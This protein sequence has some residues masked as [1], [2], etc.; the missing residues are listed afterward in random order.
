M[1]VTYGD[2]NS[3]GMM[4]SNDW[5]NQGTLEAGANIAIA[6]L[7]DVGTSM[8]N[9]V[10]PEAM[11]ISTRGIL[12]DIGA[13]GAVS[14]YDNNRAAVEALSF[15]G[16]I[17]IPGMAATKIAS[18]VRAGMRGTSFLSDLRHKDDLVKFANLIEGGATGTAEYRSLRNG[19]YGR[20]A[21][22]NLTDAAAAEFAI[23]S[24][25]NAHPFMEDYMKN[26]VENFAI[27]M[28]I[29]GGV[30]TGI[31]N[32]IQR[33]ELRGITG[34]V[35][36]TATG[37]VREAAQLHASSFSDTAST[38]TALN[39]AA[40]NLDTLAEQ[41]TT[42]PL[43]KEI[44]RSW[45]AGI[46]ANMGDI[47]RASASE[48][49][50]ATGTDELAKI[51]S[52][53][54]RPEFMGAEKFDFFKSAAKGYAE[55]ATPFALNPLAVF[56]RTN[57][58]GKEV[59]IPA[60]FYSQDSQ[61]FLTRENANLLANAADTTSVAGVDKLA[62]SL[63]LRRVR[64]L[65]GEVDSFGRSGDVEAHYLANMK[66]YG[67]QTSEN[68]AAA[69]IV[70]GDMP[71]MH[72]WISAVTQKTQDA[73]QIINNP[74]STA[75][76][77]A[78]AMK[79]L[80]DLSN[81]RLKIFNEDQVKLVR[82][83]EV[84][85][86]P[87][88]ATTLDP[89]SLVSPTYFDDLMGSISSGNIRPLIRDGFGFTN[90]QDIAS[91]FY[92]MVQQKENL[93]TLADM[94]QVSARKLED[95]SRQYALDNSTKILGAMDEGAGL[96]AAATL[97]LIRWIGGRQEDKE[98]FR[99]AM[100]SARTMRNG[101][102]STTPF[103]DELA[104]ILRSPRVK[105]QMEE[106]TKH[107]DAKGNIYLKRGMSQDAVGDTP[108][109][110]YT[111]NGNIASGFGKVS[112]YKIHKD[113]VVGYLYRGE[114]EWLVGASARDTVENAAK[115]PAP[116]PAKTAA[117]AYSSTNVND[118]S[119]AML[120]AKN[121]SIAKAIQDGMAPEVAAIRYNTSKEMAQLAAADPFAFTRLAQAK[122]VDVAMTTVN[123]WNSPLQI[124]DA[125]SATRKTLRVSAAREKLT[126]SNGQLLKLHHDSLNGLLNL[127][128]QQKMALEAMDSVASERI[129]SK[130]AVLDEQFATIQK[131]WVE[132]SVVGS[133]SPLLRSMLGDVVDSAE[134]KTLREG[135][136]QFVNGKGGNPLYSSADFVTSRM[137]V[138]GR[139][140]TA[141]GDRR[142]ELANRE[143]ERLATP[144]AA[145]FKK[146]QKDEVARTEFAMMDNIRQST[147][148]IAKY[149]PVERTWVAPDGNWVPV[150]GETQPMAPIT[151]LRVQSD[152]VHEALIALDEASTAIHAT[153]SGLNRIKGSSPPNSI[154]T[155]IPSQYLGNKELAYVVNHDTGSIKLLAGNNPDDLKELVKSYSPQANET[156]MTREQLSMDRAAKLYDRLDDVTRADT[157]KLKKG[158]G[159]VA[160]DT[161]SD[162]LAD[163]VNGLRDRVNYQATAFVENSMTDLFQKLDYM[164]AVNNTFQGNKNPNVFQRA[165]NKVGQK[166]TAAD[167]KDI[168]L[169]KNPVH[170]SEFMGTINKTTSATIQLGLNAF[171]NAYSVVKPAVD[172]LGN[173]KG[174]G[175]DYEKF[176]T[177][178]KAQ[179]IEDPFKAFNEAAR[180]ALY[181]RARNSGYSVT[182]DRIINA[183]NA[184]ASTMALKFMELAQP[185]VNMMSAPILATSVISRSIKAAQIENGG[186]LLRVSSMATMMNGVRRAHSAL[187]ENQKFLK[188]F[189]QDGLFSSIVSEAD[190]VIKMSRFGT[191]S[192][193]GGLE[194]ALDSKFVQVMSKPSEL[195]ESQLRR[196]TLMTGVELGRRIYGPAASDRQIAIYARDFLKQSLGNYSTSQRPMMFQGSF[197]AAMGLFQTYMLTY[198]QS[199]YR[200][201]D[202]K[203]YK[204]LGKTMLA[205]GGIFG[206]GSLPGFHPVSQAIGEHFSDEHWDL[207]SGTYRALPSGLADVLIYGMPSNIAPDVHT[208]GDV[209]PRVPN[210][211]ST[212]VAPSMVAQSF[213]TLVNVAKSM[214][215][216]DVG[217]GQ[218]FMEALSTQ[219]VSRP[220]A[221][222]SELA[223]GRSITGQGSQVAGPEEVWSA[224]GIMAR[225]FSTRTLQETKVREATHLNSYYGALDSDARKVVL[226]RMRTAIRAGNLDNTLMDDLAYDYLRVGSPQGFRMSVN[227]ALMESQNEGLVDL[228]Q[229]L[230]QSPLMSI[231][232]DID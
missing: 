52:T 76:E 140:V 165:V 198:A 112:T 142:T 180:P 124:P 173:I 41:A 49:L 150:K 137:G 65:F 229:R 204:G 54:L 116:K 216:Y 58:K 64:N 73:R 186:D 75:V 125:L 230:K 130:V 214:G 152:S 120:A 110:S 87:T 94:H 196:Y 72:G 13:D 28:L 141:I 232:E 143:F 62:A 227:Q 188:M 19:I 220:I 5:S 160:P 33:A 21:L 81:A 134:M 182:P 129:A 174:N 56:T 207:V 157:T 119:M 168:L 193:V 205:Q 122:G 24:T 154:G 217:A 30:G 50:L 190:E 155:W 109:S 183:G 68:L 77:Q 225:V 63:S 113:D 46:Q 101:L 16:G 163:I 10:T 34:T 14:A 108:V 212:M 189:E 179:G 61:A 195:A 175:P 194:K 67:A 114:S 169:G 117:S 29:G 83:D 53:L 59:F 84:A 170:R 4:S 218:A 1:A 123:R 23:M 172:K 82:V 226:T 197:G 223:T 69:E 161:S 132:S 138:V 100:A 148:G 187:P 178:L 8:W 45:S 185:L 162:R 159:L 102:D 153:Q 22:N 231:L 103:H 107:A 206:A 118:A 215:K 181:E 145:Q 203:D 221:R 2:L 35:E 166:D 158:I 133:S 7:V 20:N 184:L 17:L 15:V 192:F 99:N 66:F 12:Q 209:S 96:D 208:R 6:T 177:M 71:A 9:S 210:S 25:M 93:R 31:G 171:N 149:D 44:A 199:M 127:N 164:S 36:A 98:L 105:S 144:I 78:A 40:G 97:M 86:L 131:L 51:R 111:A 57:T 27:G 88:A 26:P 80:E 121:Q 38:L 37:V 213:D 147:A 222:L 11:E 70:Q 128:A 74:S 191:G 89:S 126:D 92:R 202:L 42:S 90:A 146:F 85:E 91:G 106:L 176:N 43:A 201:L 139:L 211:I 32:L 48:S 200:H 135:L 39:I 224:Q 79:T 55:P 47:F 60:N 151:T 95:Y 104:T 228:S 219:S 156:I 3:V 136:N 18:G 115:A 167:I